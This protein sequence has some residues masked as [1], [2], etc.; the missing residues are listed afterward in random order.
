M[1]TCLESLWI[2]FPFD[3]ADFA[4]SAS[5]GFNYVVS[6]SVGM[7]QDHGLPR[8]LGHFS[9]NKH[10]ETFRLFPISPI[11]QR[12]DNSNPTVGNLVWRAE[13]SFMFPSLGLFCYH[14]DRVWKSYG[15]RRFNDLDQSRGGSGT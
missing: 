14:L 13:M 6:K 7:P 10:V 12:F 3:V 11:L 8:Q 15:E 5:G 2:G 4:E 9:F 1:S